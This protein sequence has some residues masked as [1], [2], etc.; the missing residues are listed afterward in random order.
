MRFIPT[1]IHGILDYVVG[2]LTIALPFVLG[3]SGM[4]RTVLLILGC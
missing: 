1:L 4:P 3:L 2:V